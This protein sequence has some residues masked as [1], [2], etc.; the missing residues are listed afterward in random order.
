MVVI[1]AISVTLIAAVAL[2]MWVTSVRARRRRRRITVFPSAMSVPGTAPRKLQPAR[3]AVSIRRP[4]HSSA[5]RNVEV[6]DDYRK[7]RASRP[8]CARATSTD[9]TRGVRSHP[10]EPA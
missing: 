9:T 8:R 4:R 1:V 10:P 7:A 3:R 5:A 6:L 2:A